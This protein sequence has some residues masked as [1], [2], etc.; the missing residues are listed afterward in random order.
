M[1]VLT[2]AEPPPQQ[3]PASWWHLHWRAAAGRD[4]FTDTGLCERIRQRILQAHRRPGR[5]LLVYAVLP[6]EI[7]LVAQLAAGQG[8]RGL[9]HGIGNLVSRWVGQCHPAP[10]PVFAGPYQGHLMVSLAELRQTIRLLAWRPVRLGVAASPLRYEHA[11]LRTALG[12]QVACGFD[13]RPLL[14]LFADST[15]LARE[16]LRALVSQQPADAEQRFWELTHGLPG[17]GP[18]GGSRLE[19]GAAALLAAAGTGGV[20][21][22]L[23]LLDV[24]VAARLGLRAGR[25]GGAADA[26]AARGRALVACLAVDHRLCPAAAAARHFGRARATLC[27]QMAVCRARPVDRQMLATPVGRIVEEACALVSPMPARVFSTGR[28]GLAERC[29]H[30]GHAMRSPSAVGQG[31]GAR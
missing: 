4:V 13:A 27:E 7:H 3:A 28:A 9:A 2:P 12:L 30:G 11:S 24:W 18:A 20:P 10:G 14:Q 1:D 6:S 5:V 16:Q 26:K 17:D 23:G 8:A 31:A 21:G 15:P 25:C 22:A 19:P 29:V